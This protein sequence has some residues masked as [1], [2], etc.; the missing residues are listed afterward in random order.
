MFGQG[1]HNPLVYSF[2]GNWSKRIQTVLVARDFDIHLLEPYYRFEYIDY[3]D[4]N[5]TVPAGRAVDRRSYDGVFRNM[6]VQVGLKV[7]CWKGWF[8]DYCI[9]FCV[10]R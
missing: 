7:D 3:I 9:T 5:W 6:V 4:V 8:G 10:A 2:S 1:L